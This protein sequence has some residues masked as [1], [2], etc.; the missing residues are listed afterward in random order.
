M[1]IRSKSAIALVCA[2][3]TL[4]PAG[5]SAQPGYYSPGYQ[6]QYNPGQYRQ[7]HPAVV[8]RQGIEQ[9]LKFLEGG[10]AQNRA[11]LEEFVKQEIAPYF[12]FA[13][14]TRWALGPRARYL[15]QEQLLSVARQFRDTFLEAVVRQLRHYEPG[16]VEYLPSQ[17][18]PRS[19]RMT[20]SLRSYSQRGYPMQLDLDFHRSRDGWKIYDVSA[21]GQSA[22]MAYREFFNERFERFQPY[23]APPTNPYGYR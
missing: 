13:Y 4:L 19:G 16:R 21:N 15:S 5:I 20:L 18:S 8:L 22:L 14:M 12:D 6:P 9:V 11:Q 7:L 23:G 10:G 3:A 17:G 1:A 2:V